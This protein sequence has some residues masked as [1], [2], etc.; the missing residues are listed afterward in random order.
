MHHKSLHGVS[1]VQG[2][3]KVLHLKGWFQNSNSKH[4]VVTLTDRPF[5]AC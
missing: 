5:T 2:A 3:D 1:V 4:P